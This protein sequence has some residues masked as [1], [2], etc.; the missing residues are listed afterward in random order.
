[1]PSQLP[2]D[3]AT[4]AV[5]LARTLH[6]HYATYH[7]HKESMAYA[8]FTAYLGIVG[9]A[10]FTDS[11]PP[12]GAHAKELGIG[13]TVVFWIAVLI[14]L[15]FQLLRRRWAALRQAGCE[16]LLARWVAKEPSPDDLRLATTKSR[17]PVSTWLLV[18]DWL[19]ARKDAVRAVD[20]DQSVYPQVFVDEW[21]KR[22]LD[23]T[24]AIRHERLILLTGWVLFIALLCR[25]AGP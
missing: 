14:Y 9:A 10:L 3:A 5:E 22:E 1:M 8:G 15:K 13:A 20:T 4:R 11:W 6:D 12:S 24:S 16:R 19:V 21:V 2:S 23:G 7:D 18:T 25:S 17:A